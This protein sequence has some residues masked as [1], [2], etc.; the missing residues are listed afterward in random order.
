MHGSHM[1]QVWLMH[2]CGVGQARP[3]CVIG[4]GGTWFRHGRQVVPVW[5]TRASSEADLWFKCD[6]HWLQDGLARDIGT[7]ET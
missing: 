7:A 4:M 6:W 5:L 1:V 2:V 3:T